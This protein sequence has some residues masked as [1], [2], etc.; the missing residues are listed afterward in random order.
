MDF[1][2]FS[3]RRYVNNRDFPNIRFFASTQSGQHAPSIKHLRTWHP[4]KVQYGRRNVFRTNF[5]FNFPLTKE[6]PK[7]EKPRIL[8]MATRTRVS[9]YAADFS[10]GRRAER[11]YRSAMVPFDK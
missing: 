6:G 3:M 4:K 9:E 1:C 5:F 11:R 8:H 2:L 10:Y 7:A